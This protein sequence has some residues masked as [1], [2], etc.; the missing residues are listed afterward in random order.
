MN[1]DY[2]DI[3]KIKIKNMKIR[4]IE[5]ISEFMACMNSKE[6]N[7]IGYCG[8]KKEEILRCLNEYF[9]EETIE[10]CF[11]GAY[12]DDEIVGLLGVDTD[13]DNG[14]GELWG[15][16]ISENFNKEEI[17]SKLWQSLKASVSDYCKGFGMFCSNKNKDCLEFGKRHNFIMEDE[18][19]IMKLNKEKNQKISEVKPYELTTEYYTEFE[20][21]HD[22]VFRNSYYEGKTIVSNIND[23]RKVFIIKDNNE[24]IAYIYIEVNP[25]FHESSIDFFAVREDKRG[26]GLG[27]RLI[28]IAIDWIFTFK[29]INEITLCVKEKNLKAL[30]LYK[31]CGFS[32]KN[33]MIFLK[34]EL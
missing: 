16:F 1:I 32:E 34:I 21:F 11:V 22:R 17:S 24:V 31:K 13:V 28:K 7:Y 10:K 14:F 6:S 4:E 26:K 12:N 23:H 27:I 19:F 18:F 30:G 20:K 2:N 9:T 8:D 29:E 3:S 5:K 33:H 15:P 25:E